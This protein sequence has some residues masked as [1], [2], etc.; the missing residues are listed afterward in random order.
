MFLIW[1]SCPLTSATRLPPVWWRWNLRS[2][3]D[4]MRD[5]RTFLG[6]ESAKG[7]QFMKKTKG[8]HG[9]SLKENQLLTSRIQVSFGQWSGWLHGER[10]VG[11]R[12]VPRYV[13]PQTRQNT[14]SIRLSIC[15]HVWIWQRLMWRPMRP[16]WRKGRCY[17]REQVAA[18]Q[19][20]VA[21]FWKDP[22]KWSEMLSLGTTLPSQ[23]E[24]I[25]CWVLYPSLSVSH[26]YTLI[27][28]LNRFV[29]SSYVACGVQ[30]TTSLV[31]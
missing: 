30:H 5:A 31:S 4:G 25:Y 17:W 24:G 13:Y 3:T 8:W 20:T 29:C 7:W 14:L 18:L 23:G 11:C 27:E 10:G 28:P 26:L 15:E 6:M 19:P 9:W 22:P 2:A 12:Y 16:S 1:N 21:H